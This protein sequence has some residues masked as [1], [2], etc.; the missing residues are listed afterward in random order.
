MYL[1]AIPPLGVS[2]TGKN[3]GH[4]KEECIWQWL[5]STIRYSL[6]GF[7]HKNLRSILQTGARKTT[8][9]KVTPTAL[10]QDKPQYRCFFKLL[11]RT[12]RDGNTAVL[13]ALFQHWSHNAS[14]PTNC[15]ILCCHLSPFLIVLFLAE[16]R[17][18]DHL[19]LCSS[20]SY[21]WRLLSSPHSFSFSK[22][23]S[24]LT[25]AP[26]QNWPLSQQE[27]IFR[28][29][30]AQQCLMISETPI[31]SGSFLGEPAQKLFFPQNF[32][33]IS[34]KANQAGSQQVNREP[35]LQ[36]HCPCCLFCCG[37]T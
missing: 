25:C 21:V 32:F 2:C 10:S 13:E 3:Q 15:Y 28:E 35:Q 37:L 9:G 7:P 5:T 11:L 31:W 6:G 29:G 23:G 36:T 26:V 19:P 33:H 18:D 1:Q 27:G 17:N 34:T 14:F 16:M 24:H 8:E 20:C 30:E 4:C 22:Q 12:C